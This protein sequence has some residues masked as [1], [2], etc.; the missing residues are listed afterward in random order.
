MESCTATSRFWPTSGAF[1]WRRPRCG[2]GRAAT[3]DPS[4][5]PV[6][7]RGFFDLITV[8]FLTQYTRRPLHFFGWVG[9]TTLVAGFAINAYLAVLWFLGQGIGTRPL[10]TLGVLLMIIG[11]PFGLFGLLGEMIASTSPR[12]DY[13][14]RR[15]L[16]RSP[17]MSRSARHD[18]HR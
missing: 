12:R 6:G 8:L 16:S 1:G 2:T 13:A 10:L 15:H 7:S 14:V 11:A 9:L 5:A 3:A 18:A 17:M 4:S